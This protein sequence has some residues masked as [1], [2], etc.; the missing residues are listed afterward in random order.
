MY[1]NGGNKLKR[2]KKTALNAKNITRIRTDWRKNSRLSVPFFSFY[3]LVLD[4]SFPLGI[5]QVKYVCR[6]IKNHQNL[7]IYDD[8]NKPFNQ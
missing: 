8:K 1:F 6:V 5:R 2:P 7:D 3:F 4:A